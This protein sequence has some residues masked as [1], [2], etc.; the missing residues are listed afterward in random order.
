MLGKLIFFE[1]SRRN[2]TPVQQVLDRGG[3]GNFAHLPGCVA[4]ALGLL[5]GRPAV[6]GIRFR[7][8]TSEMDEASVEAN[9]DPVHRYAGI[10]FR[11]MAIRRSRR[12]VLPQEA[13][14]NQPD[15]V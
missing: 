11:D 7:R 5:R 15:S 14:P 10:A 1:V 8:V 12:V 13:A 2:S 3:E 6:R 9:P 4:F